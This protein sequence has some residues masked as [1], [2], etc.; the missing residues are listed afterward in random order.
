MR[1]TCT[2]LS[3]ACF[4]SFHNTIIEQQR[5][6]L[7]CATI[8]LLAWVSR[9]NST[10]HVCITNELFLSLDISDA[11]Q[12]STQLFRAWFGP[13]SNLNTRLELLIPQTI[14]SLSVPKSQVFSRVFNSVRYLSKL[15]PAYW[16]IV[17]KKLMSFHCL[18]GHSTHQTT[19]AAPQSSHPCQESQ[20]S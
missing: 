16:Y 10:N 2:F 11:L 13:L 14:L 8:Y 9:I 7:L 18:K 19:W 12:R 17:K 4:V 20:T 5:R 6:L 15:S 1:S 3:T